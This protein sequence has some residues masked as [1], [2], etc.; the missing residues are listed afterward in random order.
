MFRVS[1]IAAQSSAACLGQAVTMIMSQRIILGLHDWRNVVAPSRGNTRPELYE[2]S[3]NKRALGRSTASGAD[4][5]NDSTTVI[6]PSTSY[7]PSSG[8]PLK[9][10]AP[11][12]RRTTSVDGGV[13]HVHVQ[14]DVQEDYDS[15]YTHSP[16]YLHPSDD[17]STGAQRDEKAWNPL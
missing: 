16:A 12:A 1:S 8:T 11:S 5:A 9:S 15:M 7:T 2:L 17:L 10:F 4:S 13:V 14:H 6:S 3:N